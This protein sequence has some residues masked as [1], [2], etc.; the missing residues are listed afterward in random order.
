[1]GHEVAVPRPIA[2][3]AIAVVAVAAAES[4]RDRWERELAAWLEEHA[5]AL[6]RG[7]TGLEV[8][9]LAWS[10]EHF[11]EQ[12]RFVLDAVARGAHGADPD[13]RIALDRLAA[14]IAGHERSWVLAGRRWAWPDRAPA[15][16]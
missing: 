8:A 15:V 2:A 7:V 10:P 5:R 14:L 3:R 4:A 13:V 11:A 12:Q 6:A 1:M 9:A 16:P